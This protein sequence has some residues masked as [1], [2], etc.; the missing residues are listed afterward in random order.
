MDG[1]N[2]TGCGKPLYDGDW[3]SKSGLCRACA[4]AKHD[5]KPGGKLLKNWW[6]ILIVAV[7]AVIGIMGYIGS[8]MPE[9]P[10]VIIGEDGKPTEDALF[11]FT[12]IAHNAVKD[13]LKAPSTAEFDETTEV[14]Y[15]YE[16]GVYGISGDVTAENSFGVPLKGP[17][18]V[19][20]KCWGLDYGENEVLEVEID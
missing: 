10:D 1:V 9:A 8:T 17:Y 4:E 14:W 18:F 11:R 6:I 3:K 12:S 5:A 20:F 7:F 15:M 2:C 19:K 16:D 13:N